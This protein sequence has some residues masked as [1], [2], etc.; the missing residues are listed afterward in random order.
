MSDKPCKRPPAHPRR[1]ARPATALLLAAALFLAGSALTSASETDRAE[2]GGVAEGSN[3]RFRGI[4]PKVEGELSPIVRVKLIAA[5]RLASQ[6]VATVPACQAMFSELGEDGLEKLTHTV[7]AA[8]P[9]RQKALPGASHLEVHAYT[10]V[11]SSRVFLREGFA[12]LTRRKAAVLLI[13]EALHFSGLG[14]WPSEPDGLTTWQIGQLVAGRC[15]FRG[16]RA[17]RQS[18]GV[19]LRQGRSARG[20]ADEPE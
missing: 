2:G 9:R 7:Y 8:A 1:R 4:T 3:R 17:A 10:H 11:D 5:F 18:A 6:R 14:E 16:R 19:A 12:H 15:G 20:G 13:H